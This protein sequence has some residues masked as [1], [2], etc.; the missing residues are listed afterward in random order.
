MLFRYRIRRL[1]PENSGR[2]ESVPGVK[3]G[4]PKDKNKIH[5]RCFQSNDPFENEPPAYTLILGPRV[6]RKRR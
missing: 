2:R 4:I 6:H 5:G 1:I 3:S